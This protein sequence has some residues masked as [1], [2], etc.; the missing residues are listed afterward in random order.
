MKPFTER[1][2]ELEY[3]KDTGNDP[4]RGSTGGYTRGFYDW[5]LDQL[6]IFKNKENETKSEQREFHLGES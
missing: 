3:Q 6:I 4:N 5:C 2:L 1:D